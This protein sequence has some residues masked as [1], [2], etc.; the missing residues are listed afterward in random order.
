[1]AIV[2]KRAYEQAES[3]DGYRVLVDRLWPRGISKARAGVDEWLKEIAPSDDLRKGLHDGSLTWDSFR[4][5][6]LRQLKAYREVLRPLA[7]RATRERVTLVFAARDERRNN[8]VVARQ[9]LR[10]LGAR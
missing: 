6:Y 9:Y 8:A 1:M 5:A 2:L 10:M 3:T 7:R 4:K